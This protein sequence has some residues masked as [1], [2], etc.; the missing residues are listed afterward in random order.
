[1]VGKRVVAQALAKGFS[2]NAFGR[3]VED[4]IDKDNRDEHLSAIKGY[5]FD[6]TDVYKAVKNADAVI[7]IL[8]GAFDGTDKS[9]SLGIKNIIKQMEKAGVKRIVALGGMGVLNANAG[10]YVMDTPEYPE[11]YKAVGQEH[12]L[13][14]L[15][16][17]AS[18]LDWT[19]VCP[20]SILKEEGNHQYTTSEDYLPQ[21]NYDEIAVGDLSEFI[22]TELTQKKYVRHRVGISRL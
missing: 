12:L 11:Q 22:L 7:S 8:G 1:M 10:H 21:P 3:N 13:A 6:E 17:Q 14:Y 20:P 19:F 18:S 15:F 9:R 16:L 4:L 5:V 2:V